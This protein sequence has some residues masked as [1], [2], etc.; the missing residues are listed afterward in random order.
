[1]YTAACRGVAYYDGRLAPASTPVPADTGVSTLPEAGDTAAAPQDPMTADAAA[2]T[3]EAAEQPGVSTRQPGAPLADSAPC[4]TRIIEGTLDA[5]LV[6][7][8]ARTGKPCADFGDNGQVDITVGMGDVSPGMVSITSAPTIVRG[9]VVTGHQVLDGQRRW[10][11]SG[12]IQGFDAI[13]GELRWAWDMM[14]PDRSG[15]PPE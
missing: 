3:A 7:V 5:R 2:A 12:V 14:R 13:T 10:A 4:A 6:A 9:V 1:P 8:D 11:P 15:L